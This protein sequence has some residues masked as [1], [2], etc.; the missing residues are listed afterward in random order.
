ML[1]KVD[2]FVQRL[3]NLKET[4]PVTAA[5]TATYGE[6]LGVL[7]E[8]RVSTVLLLDRGR[9]AGVFT[10]RDV[11]NKCILEGIPLSTPI[12]EL[13]TPDPVAI[14]EDA[15]VGEAIARMHKHHVRNLP[16]KD[17]RGRLTGLLTVG[18]LIRFLAFAFP[19]EV[20]NLPPKPAQVTEEVEGA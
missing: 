1:A 14:R 19:A 11:L 10:E 6:V 12:S 17:A 9:L 2:P 18:R 20:V 8:R 16:M 4:E 7:R 15:T 13:M 3:S 5:A